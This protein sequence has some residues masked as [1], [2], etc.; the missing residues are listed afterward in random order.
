[1]AA[2]LHEMGGRCAYCIEEDNWI[3]TDRFVNDEGAEE[4]KI[5]C[6]T[7]RYHE[8]GT[9]YECGNTL[10]LVDGVRQ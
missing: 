8:D 2:L 7:T 4:L 5:K 9:I 10:E 1:M 6:L 3:T